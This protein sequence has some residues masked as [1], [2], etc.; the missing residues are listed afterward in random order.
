MLWSFV[1][2]GRKM[3]PIYVGDAIACDPW[4]QDKPVSVDATPEYRDRKAFRWLEITRK[5]N[6]PAGL[7]FTGSRRRWMS[8][9]IVEKDAARM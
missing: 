8:R 2:H 7:L 3:N 5:V 6:S 1:T 4:T 9:H